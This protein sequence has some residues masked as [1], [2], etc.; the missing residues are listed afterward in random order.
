VRQF[1]GKVI[2][3]S[4]L[5][6]KL[7]SVT[8]N[9]IGSPPCCASFLGSLTPS[10]CPI[11]PPWFTPWFVITIKSLGGNL[12]LR[13]L[14][15]N[16]FTWRFSHC[17]HDLVIGP[18][19]SIKGVVVSDIV[20]SSSEPTSSRWAFWFES[21]FVFS[22]VTIAHSLSSWPFVG[23][24]SKVASYSGTCSRHPSHDI[25]ITLWK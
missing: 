9:W 16:E 17:A 25:N 8:P 22:G 13:S 24:P 18:C 5:A 10:W 14:A 2:L 21:S 3:N 7:D 23:S 12:F 11:C 1:E 6:S 4:E 20:M 19:T 15:E